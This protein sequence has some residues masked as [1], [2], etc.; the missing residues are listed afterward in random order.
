MVI[1]LPSQVHS[2]ASAVPCWYACT[3]PEWWRVFWTVPCDKGSQGRLCNGINTVLR[4]VCR[5]FL[6]LWWWLSNQ[7]PL[8][9]QAGCKPKRRWRHVCLMNFYRLLPWNKSSTER[10]MQRVMD[11][12]SLDCDN[13]YYDLKSAPASTWTAEL[14]YQPAPGRPS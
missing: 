13:R 9:W 10:K 11:R 6:W 14:V 5:C 8:W 1:R 4:D 2:N 12:V 7:I 3:G